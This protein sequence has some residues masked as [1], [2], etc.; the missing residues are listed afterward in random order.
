MSIWL[1]PIGHHIGCEPD[2]WA[3][4]WL[5]KQRSE[6]KIG[7]TV[8]KRGGVHYLKRAT[9]KWD[10]ETRK[11]R[12]IWTGSTASSTREAGSQRFPGPHE[13]VLHFME[14]E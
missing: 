2:N 1:C 12:K 5:E 7:L 3:K 6:G 11:R 14:F 9:T 8:E 13:P 4:E 10:P